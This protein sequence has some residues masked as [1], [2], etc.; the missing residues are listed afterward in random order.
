SDVERHASR[1]PG[2]HR[3]TYGGERLDG[4]V[5]RHPRRLA[6][7]PILAPHHASAGQRLDGAED[8]HLLVA[9][10][11]HTATGGRLHRQERGDLEQM[12]LYDVAYG[13]R[14]VVEGTTVA[15]AEVLGHGD[16]HALHVVAVPDGLQEGVGEAEV[17]QVLH[18]LLAEVV[19]DAEDGALREG[20]RQDA[21]EGVRRG[22]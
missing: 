1:T 4:G 18:R 14:L 5:R 7:A 20:A 12:I 13:A 17:D 15:H 22:E 8:A 21:V 16:L 6:I 9:E 3:E 11:I 10:S 19:V 2:I